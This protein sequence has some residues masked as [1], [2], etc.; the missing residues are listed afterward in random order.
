MTQTLSAQQQIELARAAA[1]GEVQAR[2]QVNQMIHPVIDYHTS[3]FCKRFC[4]QKRFQYRC[5]LSKP[6]G[7][8]S[9]E[10]ALCEWGNAS[11]G[12]MLNDLTSSS[13]LNKF[14][15]REG[16]SLFDYLYRIANSLPFYERWKDWR[17]GRSIHVPTYVVA[18]DEHAKSVFYALHSGLSPQLIAQQLKIGLP[19]VERIIRQIV[20]EL[21]RHH[22]LYLLDP[23]KIQSLTMT[24]EHDEQDSA[25]QMDVAV[26]DED[27]LHQDQQQHINRAWKSLDTIEQFVLEALVINEQD[28]K[29]VLK[30]LSKLDIVIKKGVRPEHTSIQQLYYFKR[31]SL[32]KLQQALE[33]A[34]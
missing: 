11:Y 16:A 32:S 33:S 14:G 20:V 30:A 2:Q 15:A 27:Y 8:L 9:R 4:E 23:P 6:W 5:T 24:A 12:W 18:I 19:D 25:M 28:A 1:R 22:R 21:T 10:A 31:K 17:F 29:Q 34:G 13:R 3:V 7:A 26:I